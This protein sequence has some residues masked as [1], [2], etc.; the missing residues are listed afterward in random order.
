MASP[1]APADN[2]EG[3]GLAI[4]AEA[5]FLVNL[6]ALPGLA[7]AAL[8]WLWWRH[9]GTAPLLA[10]QHLQQTFWVS[11]WGGLLIVTLSAGFI[12]LGG[13]NWEWTWVA[14]ILYFTCV[15][16]ALVVGGIVGLANAMAGQPWRFPLIGP[17]LPRA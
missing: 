11:A 10:R 16:S 14:V 12:A 7:F 3:T 13:L 6:L 4:A 15:H 2:P 17:R 8:A 5:L 1:S 9:G